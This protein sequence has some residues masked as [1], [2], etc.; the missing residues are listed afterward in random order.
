MHI[1]AYNIILDII[2]LIYTFIRVMNFV[3]GP[4]SSTIF[5]R[6]NSVATRWHI[7]YFLPEKTQQNRSPNKK[8]TSQLSF[9]EI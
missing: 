5:T 7:I 6:C 2:T 8:A 9:P 3:Q 4:Y 1:N